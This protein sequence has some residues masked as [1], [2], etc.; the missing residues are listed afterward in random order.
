MFGIRNC[1]HFFD[2]NIIITTIIMTPNEPIEM[3]RLIEPRKSPPLTVVFV[4]VDGD[5]DDVVVVVSDVISGV[6]VV[7]E[8]SSTFTNTVLKTTL[9]E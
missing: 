6:V 3:I 5:D 4:V 7:V 1:A 9:A 2:F 8:C